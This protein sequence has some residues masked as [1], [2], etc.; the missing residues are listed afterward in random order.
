MRLINLKNI[1]KQYI[2]FIVLRGISFLIIGFTT[3]LGPKIVGLDVFGEIEY[4]IQLIGLSSVFL[5]G[6]HSG[7]GY[8]H[9][10]NMNPMTHNLLIIGLGHAVLIFVFLS[11]FFNGDLMSFGV[12]CLVFSVILEQ[13]FKINNQFNLAIL[14]KPIVSLI[15]CGFY[16]KYHFFIELRNSDIRF[17]INIIYFLALLVFSIVYFVKYYNTLEGRGT[18]IKEYIQNVKYGFEPNLTTSIVLLFF[19]TDRFFIKKY[20]T[21]DLGTYSIAYNF[22]LISYLFLSSI[23][24]VS[25]I[26]IGEK[27]KSKSDV[28]KY[29]RK[30]IKL[31]I[32]SCFILIALLVPL[33]FLVNSFWFD[34]KLF[35]EVALINLVGKSAFGATAIFSP[36]IF[37]RRKERYQ[38][39]VLFILTMLLYI[40]IESMYNLMSFVTLQ[41]I[42]N[43]ILL[44]YSIYILLLTKKIINEK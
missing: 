1:P 32:I 29:V 33:I 26:K 38:W 7:Y 10:H 42:S 20:F 30:S 17:S 12:G 14:Y 3:F 8:R 23:G 4:E 44:I 37:Y 41:V 39:V 40:S 35:K 5:F 16:M 25:N 27:L 13:L 22:A 11:Y 6:A 28:N 19:F 15:I 18:S 24:Y 43:I 31:S 9:F 21:D 34:I 2:L 36:I